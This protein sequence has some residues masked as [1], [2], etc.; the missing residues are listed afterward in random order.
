M[1][2]IKNK[3]KYPIKETPIDSDYII[4]S[5]SEDNGKTVNFTLASITDYLSN[6]VEG[7]IQD[8]KNK[9][10]SFLDN[11]VDEDTV[12]TRLN[13]SDPAIIVDEY[14]TLYIQISQAYGQGDDNEV[15]LY[16]LKNLGKGTYG[17]GETQITSSDLQLISTYNLTGGVVSNFANTQFIELGDVGATD[18]VTAFNAHTF[19][20]S[21]DPVQ[22]QNIGY[23]LVNVTIN[24]EDL[25]YLFVGD[26]GEY[27]VGGSETAV[28]EDFVLLTDS[29][30]VPSLQ[31]V[32]DVGEITT[33]SIKSYSSSQTE[34]YTLIGTL[35]GLVSSQYGY[36]DLSKG[37]GDTQVGRVRFSSEDLN[38][39]TVLKAP[40]SSGYIPVSVSDG[41]TTE[42]ADVNGN[43]NISSLVGGTQD[44]Q[45]VTDVGNTTTNNVNIGNK[46][47]FEDSFLGRELEFESNFGALLLTAASRPTGKTSIRF[48]GGGAM[49]LYNN[50]DFSGSISASFLT[51]NQSFFLTNPAAGSGF[52][53][54]SVSDGVT[55]IY[56]DVTGNIDISPI[57]GGTTPNL[58]QVTDVG[59]S[60]N[61]GI[62]FQSDA[63]TSGDRRFYIHAEQNTP[64]ISIGEFGFGSPA[65]M[66]GFIN[67]PYNGDSTIRTLIQSV[68]DGVTTVEADSTGLV[69]ISSLIGGGASQLSDLSD[70][71][72]STPTNRNVLVADGV[73]WESR[74]LTEDDISDL[75]TYIPLSGTEV[76]SPVTGDIEVSESTKN[77]WIPAGDAPNDYFAVQFA[78]GGI[79]TIY[80]NTATN[81]TT[82]L[83]INQTDVVLTVDDGASGIGVSKGI[84]ANVYFG[85]NYTDNTYVQKKYVDDEIAAISID[86]LYSADGTLASNRTVTIG[87]EGFL[88]FTGGVGTA[89]TVDTESIA[90][91]STGGDI[92]LKSSLLDNQIVLPESSFM[93]IIAEHG[94]RLT[95]GAGGTPTPPTTGQVLAAAN[96]NGD[97]EWITP[98]GG[99]A[100]QLSDLTDVNTSTPTNR[101]VLVAD[102]VDWESRPLTEA[103]ISDFG[104][105]LTSASPLDGDNVVIDN[106]SFSVLTQTNSQSL[107]EEID[108][109]LLKARGTEVLGGT[110]AVT[111]TGGGTS[112]DVAATQGQIKDSSGY[113]FINYAGST[114]NTPIS[115]TGSIYVYIDNTGALGQQTT[116]PTRQEFREKLYITRLANSGGVLVA[117][118][119]IAN[120]SGQ[121]TNSLRDY[122]SYVSSPKKGLALSG[123][124]DLTFQV[125]AGSI[126]ELGVS[127]SSNP[128]SPN[129]IAFTLQN[130]A[131][132]FR[133]SRST[134]LG[135]ATSINVTDYDNG[136]TMTTMTNNRFK[137]LTVFKFGSGNHTLQEGQNQYTS[138]DAAQAAISTRTF[139]LNPSNETGTRIGWIIVQKDATDLTNTAQ[140]RFV[141]D[142]GSFSTGTGTTGALLASN[143]LSDLDNA[144][145]ARTNL[146]LDTTANQADSLDKRFMTDAQEAK[147][148]AITGTNTGDQTIFTIDASGYTPTNY[149]AIGG[150]NLDNHILGIDSELQT[151]QNDIATNASDIIDLTNDKVNKSGTPTAGQAAEWLNSSTI[152]GVAVTGT[153]NYVKSISPTFTGTPVLPST[154]TIG[155]NSFIRTG[156]HNL[157]LTTTATTNVTLPTTGTLLNTATAQ[158]IT[159]GVKKTFQASGST[160]GLRLAGVS[161]NPSSLVAGDIWYRTDTEKLSYRGASV[162]RSLVAEALAQTLTNKTIDGSANTISNI[163]LASQVTG[164]LPV[165]RLNSGTGASA[166]TFWRGDGTWGVPAGAGDVSKVGTPVDN[167][168]GVWTGDGTIEGTDFLKG[169]AQTSSMQITTS[170]NWL[171][172]WAAGGSVYLQIRNDELRTV[173]GGDLTVTADITANSIDIGG[174]GNNLMLDDGNV[175][176]L[177]TLRESVTIVDPTDAD[178]VT[179]FF[180]PVAITIT[181]VRS[182]ITGTTNVVFNIQHASTRTGTGL[183][184]FTSDIT[185]TS[186]SGQSNNTGFNDAT[187]PANSWVWVNIASVSG[188]PSMFHA[189]LMYTED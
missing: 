89:F 163:N 48:E 29:I 62:L 74:P 67:F 168:I 119:E 180:T 57:S 59:N 21:E 151:I 189:S 47:S 86:T 88:T 25:Q 156:A 65:T 69:D 129:E 121:Y 141:N 22:A 164:N 44:L 174:A 150:T 179:L 7:I 50:S 16:I 36:L 96:A 118:E 111:I 158:A 71:N 106:T 85:A 187:I 100:T 54:M 105:Y 4:G 162:A 75:N 43:I 82:A 19:T 52:I 167:Q 104:L 15:R 64:D 45:S 128:D 84:S 123:N 125:A 173:V 58:E 147:L 87:E 55:T 166:S 112:F 99:G 127:N 138:L 94:L 169:T 9:V 160:A 134:S 39:T 5:D 109:A 140:A 122:L 53:P 172:F 146:G 120:P 42:F 73:D 72:T 27:G 61:N 77:L 157:T 188:T 51:A 171:E 136:G 30:T 63:P 154:V 70:V 92:T 132:F 68:T 26:G 126:F 107:F 93:S 113:Y 131:S 35:A 23:V 56:A 108:T 1:G 186:T 17:L 40:N 178:D 6:L 183:N 41:V 83:S 81:A 79:A 116:A 102:G 148:D 37:A 175:K 33:N 2:R 80:S 20:G 49:A 114:G 91:I 3:I 78:E 144:S 46:L 66:N 76:G 32:T 28:L 177:P 101:N 115:T 170:K 97:L 142:N 98:S 130:P 145:T 11:A 90:I 184:V 182:H 143:N 153:G 133:Q 161:A 34:G 110:G 38:T 24:S 137:I 152:Q 165:S 13:N 103:D 14:E 18:I 95:L 155:A 159:A 8:N 117:Q 149:T 60:T 31:Q 124:A 139:I 10:I 181:D 185:L 12:V 135:V 176:A